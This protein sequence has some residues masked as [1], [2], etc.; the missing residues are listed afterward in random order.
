MK[1]QNPPQVFLDKAQ[2]IEKYLAPATIALI[3]AIIS[4]S[5]AVLIAAVFTALVYFSAVTAAP[6]TLTIFAVLALA[7]AAAAIPL[8][9]L[10]PRDPV[11]SYIIRL[12]EMWRRPINVLSELC[13][14]KTVLVNGETLS[15]QAVF[16]FQARPKDEDL[17]EQ[18]YT[19][20]HAALSTLCSMRFSAPDKRDFEAALEPALAIVASEW[21][22]PVLYS[23]VLGVYVTSDSYTYS[24]E[25][26]FAIA[27]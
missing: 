24:D 6:V 21:K 13:T 17:R 23:T 4:V 16:Y 19:F 3:Y 14:F 25:D 7:P 20:S 18:I 22:L 15:I 11:S 26:L 5:W 1:G 12:A 27:G 10:R 2:N 8:W 9:F